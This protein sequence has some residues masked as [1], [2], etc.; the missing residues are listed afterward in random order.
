MEIVLWERGGRGD[1]ERAGEKGKVRLLR[2]VRAADRGTW[3]KNN[4]C[5]AVVGLG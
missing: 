4:E 3:Q 2:N 1:R 5:Y